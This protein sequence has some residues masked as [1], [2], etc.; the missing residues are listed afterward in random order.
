MTQLIKR[1]DQFLSE[2][3]PMLS[4]LHQQFDLP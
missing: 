1:F 3:A 4:Q 2:Q